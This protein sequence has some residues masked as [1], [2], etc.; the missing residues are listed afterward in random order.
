MPRAR[1]RSALLLVSLALTACSSASPEA[2]LPEPALPT[3]AGDDCELLIRLTQRCAEG[4]GASIACA[5]GR[6][7]QCDAERSTR[8]A[9][10]R[11]AILACV[12]DGTTCAA[13]VTGCMLDRLATAPLTEEQTKVRDDFCDRCNP[14]GATCA[15]DFFLANGDAGPGFLLLTTSDAVTA[16][17]RHAC[18]DHG[19]DSD[20]VWAFGACMRF[21]LYAALPSEPQSCRAP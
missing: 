15:R 2:A 8:S 9:A 20:C 16:R 3:A 7:A 5:D 13:D 14:A 12:D 19:T 18:I 4:A 11:Q 6:R 10:Y 17:V 1:P 21:A